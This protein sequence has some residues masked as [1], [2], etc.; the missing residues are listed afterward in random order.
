[1][2]DKNALDE[3]MERTYWHKVDKSNWPSLQE[4]EGLLHYVESMP[5]YLLK[6]AVLDMAREQ[7]VPF[8]E[9]AEYVK[10]QTKDVEIHNT[11]NQ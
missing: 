11:W 3:Y 2:V 6:L 9:F 4:V 8:T 5:N 1:M 10:K 7:P